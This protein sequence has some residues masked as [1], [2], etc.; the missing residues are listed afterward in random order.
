[1]L[2]SHRRLLTA[3]AVGGLVV[4]GC[5]ESGS[6]SA[7]TAATD[8][9]PA[10]AA[11]LSEAEYQD[12]VDDG[13]KAVSK[14]LGGVRTTST[15][16]GLQSRLEDASGSLDDASKALSGAAAP[17]SAQDHEG[18]VSAFE[19]FSAAVGDAASKV[20]SG[21]LCTG[22]AVLASLTRSG[23]AGDLR[24]AT[25][26]KALKKQPYPALRLKSGMV[27]SRKGGTGPGVLVIKNGNKREGV[28]KLRAG[29]KRMSIYVGAGKTATIQ[30]I[31]DGNFEVYFASGVSWDGK[32]NTFTRNCS[33]TRF[34]D[35]MKFVS[36]GGQY[37]Q[38]TITLNAVSGGNAPS[39]E[40]DPEDFPTG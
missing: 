7:D 11:A 39:Q 3:A 8:G 33:F 27:L 1:M 36:G 16:S 23:A 18:L 31:P 13:T 29:G 14:A 30:Q 15:R 25:G 21:A 22:P 17:D 10:A 40:I 9:T 5:G 19:G 38:F 24:A 32:R 37:T 26:V 35:K 12:L 2:A 4:A 34:E 20:E 28:V 6:S